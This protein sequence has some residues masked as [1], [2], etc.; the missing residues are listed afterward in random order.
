MEEIER[1]QVFLLDTLRKILLGANN[2][3][4]EIDRLA[5]KTFL[6]RM[7][8]DEI[9]FVPKFSFKRVL[10]P[11]YYFEKQ[12]RRSM[13]VKKSLFLSSMAEK[14]VLSR[15]HTHPTRTEPQEL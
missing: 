12:E 11:E 1:N 3:V 15:L 4:G 5:R 13:Q 8:K 14:P 9:R 7:D 6:G 10:T 2:A